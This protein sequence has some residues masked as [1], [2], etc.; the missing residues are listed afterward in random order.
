[1]S[2]SFYT[3]CDVASVA[4][5]QRFSNSDPRWNYAV[6]S[7]VL[8]ALLCAASSAAQAR[9][10]NAASPSLTDVRRAI[11]AAMHGDTVIIPAGTAA[12]T[13]ALTVT[14]GITIQGQTTVNSDNGTANDQTILVDNLA[15]VGG[16]QGFFH[17]TVNSGQSLRITGLTFTGTGGRS[18]R[19]YFNGAVRL[20]GTS[21]Q[22]RI[23]HCHF[24][25]LRHAPN[26]GV[27]STIYGVADHIVFDTFHTGC[28]SVNIYNGVGYG[29]LEWTQTAGYG[30]SHFFF[31]EDC[32]INNGAPTYY[33]PDGGVNA[34]AGGRYV[35]RYC[36]LFSIALLNHGTEE[37]RRR[38]GRAVEIYNNDYHWAFA[39]TMDGVRSG[40]LI[41]HDNT[42]FGTLPYGWGLQTYRLFYKY[43]VNWLGA[44]GDNNWDVN[45]TEADGTHIGG[46]SPYLFESG[47]VT[48]GSFDPN[49]FLS[50]LTD[51]SKSWTTNQWAHYTVRRLSDN[52]IGQVISNTSN[53][54]TMRFYR[55]DSSP[56]WAA[57]NQYQIHKVLISL[58]QPG[59]GAGDLITGN[60]PNQVNV[61]TGTVAWPH[62]A[63]EP[64]YSWNNIHSPGGEH[65]NFSPAPSSSATLL[66]GRDYYNDTPMP[67]YT[68]YTYPHPLTTGVRASTSATRDSQRNLNKNKERKAKKIKK[69]KWGGAKETSAKRSD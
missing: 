55:T 61:T 59:R 64:C 46:H 19:A 43:N 12:W 38:G 40:G 27:W 29:D 2:V 50:F 56:A 33:T 23:D 34:Q 68:P 41:V 44:S 9:T 45:V 65:I 63:L 42:L 52:F 39:L 14:K 57:G 5:R 48:S 47:T 3:G 53:T 11:A 10:I 16:D 60:P 28:E 22:V 17:C 54:L 69:W 31:I 30:S 7:S 36:H 1:M 25:D 49:H 32:Y 35:V 67:G 20:S 24:T 15:P 21:D 4:G 51:T 37:D 66:Q 13:S 8:A 18:G 26:I 6:L 58:D 62:Q